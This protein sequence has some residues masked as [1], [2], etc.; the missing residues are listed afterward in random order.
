MCVWG[1][2]GGEGSHRLLQGVRSLCLEQ[3]VA[4]VVVLGCTINVPSA[5]Q[6][7]HQ[8]KSRIQSSFTPV[9]NTS[10]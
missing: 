6:G 2:G 5:A 10:H 7:S 4:V 8:E 1:G 9:E 3:V